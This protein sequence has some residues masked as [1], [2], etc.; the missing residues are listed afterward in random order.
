MPP[1]EVLA[2]ISVVVL[3]AV[4]AWGFA[5]WVLK[6]FDA[7]HARIDEVRDVYVKRSDLDR[8]LIPLYKGIAEIKQE[9]ARQSTETNQR[10]DKILTFVGQ[11]RG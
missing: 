10:L 6:R 11:G 4:H 3:L 5:Q 7:V 9:L 2:V 8:D 1:N